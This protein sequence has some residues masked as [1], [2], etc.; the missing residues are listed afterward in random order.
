MTASSTILVIN[1][2]SSSV[3]FAVFANDASLRRLWRGR[4]ERIG[5]AVSRFAAVDASG[6]Q[7]VEECDAIADHGMALEFLFRKLERDTSAALP[8]AVGHRV[9]QGGADCD[10]P[11]I[12]TS[13]LEARLRALAPLA[14]LH[15]PHNLAGIAAVK[16]IRPGIVQVACFD[17]AFHLDLPRLARLTGLPRRFYAQGIRRYGYHGLSYEYVIEELRAREGDA[18]AHGRMIVAHLGNGVSMAAIRDA[19]SVETSMGFSTLAGLP[20]GTRSGNLDPGIVL[21][22]ITQQGMTPEQVQDLLYR[23][24]GLLGLSGIS[25]NMRELLAQSAAQAPAAEAVAFFCYR[26]RAQLAALTA[27]LGGLDRLVFTGG[28]GANAPHIRAEICKGLG[29][30]GIALDATHNADRR[31]RISAPHA[32]V[33]IE[34]FPTDEEL[35]IARHVQRVL[36]RPALREA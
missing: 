27:A 34:A 12:V 30:L 10:C 5:L 29:Y 14:P 36:E 22:L 25:R 9:V 19:R 23:Q 31:R 17:T 33:A 18:A 35:M 3:K 13:S 32:A 20:M 28:I 2:G 8:A 24:S 16:K 26:A 21:Y 7:V 11:L 4:L 1:C 15:M 6:V